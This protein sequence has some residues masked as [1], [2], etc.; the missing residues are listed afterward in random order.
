MFDPMPVMEYHSGQHILGRPAVKC[1]AAKIQLVGVDDVHS[2]LHILGD[3]AVVAD[4]EV[5]WQSSELGCH[6]SVYL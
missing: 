4:D 1:V 2:A 5:R 3:E 6:H